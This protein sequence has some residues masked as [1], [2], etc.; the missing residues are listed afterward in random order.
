MHQLKR[1]NI[2]LT[3]V[4]EEERWGRD[5]IL[6]EFCRIEELQHALRNKAKLINRLAEVKL[7]NYNM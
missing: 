5:N 6:R 4:S 1:C 3:A 7:H 2:Y